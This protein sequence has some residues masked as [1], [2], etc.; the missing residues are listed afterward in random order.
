MRDGPPRGE[1]PTV[2]CS[3]FRPEYVFP[4]GADQI[5]GTTPSGFE[6]QVARDDDLAG[7]RGCCANENEDLTVDR[8]DATHAARRID[9]RTCTTPCAI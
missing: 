9:L 1:G 2:R 8:R 7:E 6:G 5:G 4:E 3:R